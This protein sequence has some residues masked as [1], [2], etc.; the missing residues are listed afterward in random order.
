MNGLGTSMGAAGVDL[1]VVAL[2]GRPNVGKSTFLARAS[3]R[4]AETANAPGT[5]VGH[6]LRRVETRH[7][8]A[9]LADLPG[10]HSL[11]DRPLGDAP[12][13]RLLLDARPDA[14]LVL[15]DAGDLA[16]HIPL[17]LACRDLGLPVV[18]AANLSDEA[19]E[20]GIELDTGRLAQLLASPVHA[21]VGRA[22]RGVDDALA[23]AVA[24]G[25]RRIAVRD[26]TGSPRGTV[27]AAAYSPLVEARIAE[28]A[29]ALPTSPPLG[30]YPIDP[31]GLGVLVG[32][33]R[34]SARG[35][36]TI[37]LA[38]LVEPARREVAARWAGQ[39][40]SLREVPARL[41]DRLAGASVRPWPGIPLLL[42]ALA[43]TFALVM[44]VGGTLAGLL[45]AAWG[46]SVS[47]V[48][49]GAVRALVPVP[50]LASALLWGLDSGVLAL[51]SVGIPYV[52]TFYLLLAALEDSGYLTSAAVL[53]DRVL[54]ALGL[55][56]R[57]A[58]PLLAA[59]GC[60]VPA[61]YGTRVLA[62]RRERLLGAFL[63]TMTP[64][65]ARSAVVLAA[66]LPF[67]GPVATIGAFA[68]IVVLTV[69]AGIA[70]NAI[71]PGRQS[72]LVMELASLRAPVL[73]HVWAKAWFR[74]RDFL[75]TA[76]PLMIAGSVVLG[77]L[78]ETGLVWP[79][80]A[81]LDPVVVGWL[82]LPSVAGLALVFAFLRK[83]L[84]L[85]LL[86]VL[87][88]AAY[89]TGAASLGAFM[90]PGQL[91]VYA[92]VTAVSVP[93]VA[94]LAALAGELGWRAAI[95]MSAAT[96]GIAVAAG[97]V[98]ARFLGVA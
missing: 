88:V 62:T 82:G 98:L 48:V 54:G 92:I 4:F 13:W 61:V 63:V 47:P 2:V 26:G 78:Y 30:A 18:V 53:S 10:T 38:D 37:L 74:F 43:A 68:L 93:C 40:E 5:T 60:N 59:T 76:T 55:P 85:Q 44:V 71:V 50:P 41:A 80:A 11:V 23:S 28:A 35:A 16:R 75:R 79:A 20:R 8:P 25:R 31:S 69:A 32:E 56:G 45:G 36:A 27:P 52:L 95:G 33:H 64:C 73:R 51:L 15:V 58:I 12:F 1:P 34:L 86:L 39:V 19:A 42:G 94:T 72:P 6:E 89:G 22:G 24:R 66:L 87:A 3:G 83:E 67:A 7:G 65:S 81:V 46:A 14:I 29:A 96:L 57:A 17:V 21:T 90:T 70:A 49:D 9:L 91:F 84:A 77:L 97:G